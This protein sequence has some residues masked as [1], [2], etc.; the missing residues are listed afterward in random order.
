M[1][2]MNRLGKKGQNTAEY[3]ILIGLV[4]AG[5]LAMQTYVKRGMQ[6]RVHD[7]SDKYYDKMTGTA[8]ADNK[9]NWD[10]ISGAT[11]TTLTK[12]QYEPTDVKGLATQEI[13]GSTE[14]THMDT[15]GTGYR[16]YQETTKQQKTGDYQT[17]DFT[18]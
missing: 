7:A 1:R 5:A 10:A 18:K 12:K 9:A 4:I 3:A 15:G 14:T 11:A 2:I 8:D 17:K 6:G 16:E 13:T